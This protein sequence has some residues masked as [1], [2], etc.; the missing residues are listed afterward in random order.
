ME[1][2]ELEWE[3]ITWFIYSYFCKKSV[4]LFLATGTIIK[5]ILLSV[6]KSYYLES[7]SK[8][9]EMDVQEEHGIYCY[10]G[11]FSSRSV[12]SRYGYS[13]KIEIIGLDWELFKWFMLQD[14]FKKNIFFCKKLVLLFLTNRNDH[15]GAIE[16][17]RMS[18]L[19]CF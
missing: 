11:I 10:V 5:N 17:Y 16:R 4:L 2:V 6:F 14:T 19:F 13:L 12:S 1:R 9:D 8:R 15:N 7:L 3:A 18:F